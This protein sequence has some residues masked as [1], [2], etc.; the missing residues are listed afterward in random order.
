MARSYYPRASD[1]LTASLRRHEAVNERIFFINGI[2]I[3]HE[4]DDYA[5]HR[6]LAGGKYSD[7]YPHRSIAKL[8]F[9]EGWIGGTTEYYHGELPRVFMY[10]T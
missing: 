6:L 1:A 3:V 4:Y 7:W 2:R 5:N 10:F 9:K 8:R